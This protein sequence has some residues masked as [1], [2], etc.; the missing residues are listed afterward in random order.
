MT[1]PPFHSRSLLHHWLRNDE[2]GQD[3]LARIGAA[4]LEFHKD[5]LIPWALEEIPASNPDDVA[6]TILSVFGDDALTEDTTAEVAN[7]FE[8]T[9]NVCGKRYR[10]AIDEISD[11]ADPQCR[12]CRAFL[13]PLW[14]DEEFTW[15]TGCV[16][17]NG[18]ILIESGTKEAS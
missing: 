6:G 7:V 10:K 2:V 9:R 12:K 16:L 13:T 4:A 5:R 18:G 15:V 11:M 1:P 17:C 14:D 8:A 3:A